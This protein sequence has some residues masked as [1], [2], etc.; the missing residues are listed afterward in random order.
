MSI[1][2]REQAGTDTSRKFDY[3][4]AVAIDYL[5]SEIGND[6]IIIIETLEDF[7]VVKNA[8]SADRT[9]DIYQVKTK[10]KG[11]YNKAL[12]KSENVLGKIVLTDFNFN[13]A[14]NTLNIVC[15]TNLKGKSTESLNFF[16]I[17]NAFTEKEIQDV[18]TNILEY[19]KCEPSFAG[20]LSPYFGKIIYIKS[21]LPFADKDDRYNETLVGKTNTVISNYLDDENHSINPQGIFNA[22]KILVD[23]Q[24]LNKFDKDIITLDE[25]VEKKG[26]CGDDVKKLIDKA[27]ERNMLTKKEIFSH[28]ST[29][30][31][32]MEFNAIKDSYS[33]FLSYKANLSDKIYLEVM[34]CIKDEHSLLV[35]KADSINE[36]I[37]QVAQN[38]NKKITVYSLAVIQIMTII[39]VLS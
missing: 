12:L 24:R 28:A 34:Q 7:A 37:K 35:D 1:K 18:K 39:A 21:L 16:K 25:A 8:G 9:I 4:M 31:T 15:N 17:D 5:L 20:D 32:P 23:K 30:F 33:K 38:S 29:I 14:S 19:L 26:I 36:L 22:L 3:Q 2:I 6:S 13:S 11:L 10:N 27:A